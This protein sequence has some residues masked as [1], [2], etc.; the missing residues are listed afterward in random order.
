MS[1]NYPNDRELKSVKRP[2]V[3]VLL[4]LFATIVALIVMATLTFAGT[5][6]FHGATWLAVL[7]GGIVVVFV[8]ALVAS[9]KG[10][11]RRTDAAHTTNIYTTDLEE[12]E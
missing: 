3:A 6:T 5:V 2:A 4:V 8:I 12:N 1:M 9:R 11:Q 10:R 7:F